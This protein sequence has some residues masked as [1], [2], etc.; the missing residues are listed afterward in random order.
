MSWEQ[1]FTMLLIQLTKD[2]PLRQ[3]QKSNLKPY[4]VQ[5]TVRERILKILPED[6]QK[7]LKALRQTRFSEQN[8]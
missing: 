4:Y 6:F 5:G 8:Q 1:Y 2:D 7:T 3:Y